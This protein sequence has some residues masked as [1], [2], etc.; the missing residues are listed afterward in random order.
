MI[1]TVFVKASVNSSEKEKY[2]REKGSKGGVNFIIGE[3]LWEVC[4]VL[5]LHVLQSN[6]E[7]R[8]PNKS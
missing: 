1:K 2:R 3:E 5:H 4:H 7:K 8:A 6:I